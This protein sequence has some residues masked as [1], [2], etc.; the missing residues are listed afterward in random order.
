M[1]FWV[2]IAVKKYFPGDPFLP[3]LRKGDFIPQ[4]KT[5]VLTAAL[6]AFPAGMLAQRGGGGG[7]HIGG[8]SAGGDGLSSVG[9]PTGVDSKDDLRDFHAALAVQATSQQAIEF[10]Q[11]IKITEA[12]SADLEVLLEKTRKAD[13]TSAIATS[14]DRF[15]HSLET[16]LSQTRKFVEGLSEPQKSGLKEI[17]GKLSKADSDLSQGLKVLD[18]EVGDAKAGTQPMAGSVLSLQRELTSF[19]NLQL[20]LSQEMNI[21]TGDNMREAAFNILPIK[22]FVTVADQRIA[23]TTS[24]TI[25]NGHAEN[26]Q[27]PLRVELTED[28][29][30]L[31][32]NITGVLR[33]AIDK[34][35]RCGQRIAIQSAA[36]TPLPPASLVV[37]KLHFERWACFGREATNELVEGDGTIELKLTP[38]IAADGTL[39]LMP[40]I[41]RV[42]A[43][44]LIGDLL[45]S[46][47]LGE[48]LRDK[49]AES[50]FSALPPSDY[51]GM[52][53]PASQG[54]VALHHAQFQGTG[55]GRLSVVLS[56]DILISP[57]NAT[58]PGSEAK[59]PTSSAESAHQ[60]Q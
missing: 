6:L 38:A 10:K 36:L 22:T 2:F 15:G 18:L 32:Q 7:G 45:R 47:S 44:G 11:I 30:D 59:E 5:I 20:D 14:H 3:F 40:E 4:M 49:V 27:N 39:R 24:G 35:E 17:V 56:G 21:V 19:R 26:G 8:A 58:S 13:S 37:A 29:S 53:P 34:A 33:A 31:Q 50:L 48:T 16:A 51:K 28:M 23:I 60:Y 42:D 41:G 46:G 43:A 12:A 1:C 54:R 9:K 57:G 52:L 55:L 25:S